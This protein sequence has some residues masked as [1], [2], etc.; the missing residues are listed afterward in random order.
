[1]LKKK[2]LWEPLRPLPGHSQSSQAWFL[3]TMANPKDYIKEVLFHGTRGVGKTEA[4]LYSFAMHVGKGYGMKHRGVILRKTY[5]GLKDVITKSKILFHKLFGD[6]AVFLNS[7]D[8]L[9]WKWPT[10]EQLIFRAISTEKD[11]DD[12]FH[13]QEFSFIGW[14]ELCSWKDLTL[15]H[16]VMSCLRT[17]AD[18]EGQ[19][20]PPLVV[21]ATTNPYGPGVKEVKRYFIDVAK[22]GEIYK[23]VE[24]DEEG[25]IYESERCHIFGTYKENYLLPAGYIKSFFAEQ[26]KNPNRFRAWVYG[27]WNVVSGGMFGDIWNYDK[28]TVEP[29]KLDPRCFEFDRSFDWGTTSPFAALFH[30]ESNGEPFIDWE[31]NLRTIPKGSIIVF[32]EMYGAESLKDVSTGLKLGPTYVARKL[33]KKEEDL[34][35]KYLSR[36]T[37]IQPGP[38]DNSMW[39]DASTRGMVCIADKFKSEGVV[40]KQANK[41]RN[42]VAGVEIIKEMLVA[43]LSKDNTIPHLYIFNNC[44]FLINNFPVLQVSEKNPDDIDTTQPDHDYDAL[45]YRVLDMK[46][47]FTF[48]NKNGK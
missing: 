36:N 26:Y 4:L 3:S 43:T 16:M 12:N 7:K 41:A 13:G 22:Q 9:T 20:T 33:I 6:T 19:E 31:G 14:E 27:D 39:N 34:T 29:F 1:M 28:H 38:A 35:K 23:S 11:Y 15:Y 8:D 42:R 30:A 44:E 47:R 45:R 40:W 21:R 18:Y 32:G 5:K 10:G 24:M 2:I 25:D 48:T 46:S 17:S 37:V